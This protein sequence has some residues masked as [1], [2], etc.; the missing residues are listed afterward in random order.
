[1]P[2]IGQKCM[3]KYYSLEDCQRSTNFLITTFLT[4][5]L[6]LK[7]EH[8]FW[9]FQVIP[10]TFAEVRESTSY[11]MDKNGL[12]LAILILLHP[13]IPQEILKSSFSFNYKKRNLSSLFGWNFSLCSKTFS[14]HVL[15]PVDRGF[16]RG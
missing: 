6:E 7:L 16:K 11:N 5:L 1:M 14:S 3:L 13:Q 9:K 15:K 4:H 8:V 12:K 10:T 2:K